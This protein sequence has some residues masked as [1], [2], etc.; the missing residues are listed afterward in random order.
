MCWYRKVYACYIIYME[1]CKVYADMKVYAGYIINVRVYA[2]YM[3]IYAGLTSET[4]AKPPR[5][6]RETTEKTT[7]ATS[8]TTAKPP[9]NHRETI[10]DAQSA[11][12][13]PCCVLGKQFCVPQEQF[14]LPQ[15]QFCVPKEHV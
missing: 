5:N 3:Q 9:R 12:K 8:A 1:V 14:C 11:S 6:R 2:R 15:E 10:R 7:S 4:T 13:T